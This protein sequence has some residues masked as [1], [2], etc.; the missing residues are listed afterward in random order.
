[1]LNLF[2]ILRLVSEITP[3]PFPWLSQGGW[4]PTAE[5]PVRALVILTVM[6]PVSLL[7]GLL[8][9]YNWNFWALGT[10]TPQFPELAF[11]YLSSSRDF[12]NNC[13]VSFYWHQYFC[14]LVFIHLFEYLVLDIY[15]GK[16]KC[17]DVSDK[18]P[19]FS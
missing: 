5:T 6:H 13:I 16:S 1:M 19:R 12:S 14:A 8:F 7:L 2:S 9:Q 11:L 15:T 10:D 3:S 17:V 18:K 4:L